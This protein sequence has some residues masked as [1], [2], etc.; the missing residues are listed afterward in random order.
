M[1]GFVSQIITNSQETKS[2]GRQNMK[3]L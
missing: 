2:L 3:K 1:N